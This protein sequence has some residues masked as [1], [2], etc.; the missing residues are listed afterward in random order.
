[1]VQRGNPWNPLILSSCLEEAILAKLSLIPE[2]SGASFGGSAYQQEVSWCNDTSKYSA[3]L[4]QLKGLK[5]KNENKNK[6]KLGP[7]VYLLFSENQERHLLRQG[8]KGNSFGVCF[9]IGS[10]RL[11]SDLLWKR[12]TLNF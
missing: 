3:S 9:L 2:T 10:S 7:I 6:M 12:L 8:N 5:N 1:M 4:I 11:A